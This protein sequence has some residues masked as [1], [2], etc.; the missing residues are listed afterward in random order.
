MELVQDIKVE[1]QKRII[2]LGPPGAGKGTQGKAMADSAGVPYVAS[3]DLFRQH[4]EEGNP[5]AQR[6][7]E[8]MNKGLLVPDEI[9]IETILTEV[10]PPKNK[11]GFILD[12]FPRNIAQAEILDEK[13][14]SLGLSLDHVVLLTIPDVEEL[15]KRLSSRL[16]CRGC[17]AP[18]NTNGANPARSGVCDRCGHEL[19]VRP[20]D[21][22]E[23][24][25]VR[26]Q[27]YEE[28][29]QPLIRYYRRTGKLVEVI[30]TGRAED[31]SKR[32]MERVIA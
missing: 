7:Q 28:Q 29:T 19:Y 10:L 9:T 12:G 1:D 31:V 14:A 13:L 32:L 16:V 11:G 27:V 15:I 25:K 2:L 6:I 17:Q 8:Y 21:A 18:Y 22:S 4:Q 23:A 5:I 3:G 20:D 24:V 30:G 26:I